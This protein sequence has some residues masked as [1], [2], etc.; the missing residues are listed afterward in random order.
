MTE[1]EVLNAL[2]E[3]C[4]ELGTTSRMRPEILSIIA[5]RLAADPNMT[6]AKV[7]ECCKDPDA[8]MK[9]FQY[10]TGQETALGL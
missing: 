8:L 3:H 10:N 6:P 1:G 7:K 2:V 5:K 4:R 9:Y